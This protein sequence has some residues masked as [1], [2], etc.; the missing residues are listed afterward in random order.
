MNDNVRYYSLAEVDP[1]LITSSL[2]VHIH[3]MVVAGD[4]AYLVYTNVPLERSS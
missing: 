2:F 4:L 3:L 1:C